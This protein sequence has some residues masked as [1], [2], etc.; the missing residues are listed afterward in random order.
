MRRLLIL[1]VASVF[2]VAG[3]FAT[4][5]PIPGD[6]AV[7]RTLQSLFGEAPP[8]AHWLTET[9]KPPLVVATMALAAGLAWLS[10]SWRGALGIPL[11]F[12]LAWLSDKALRAMIFAPRPSSD[13]IAVAGPSSASG[14][15]STFGLVY[16]SVFGAL[17]ISAARGGFSLVARSFALLLILVGTMARVVLGGHWASQMLASVLLGLLAASIACNIS[18]R[19]L[20]R[21]AE[22]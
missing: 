1:T 6:L 21:E 16:G 13:W 3:C 10:N 17:F 18:N 5:G 2:A 9:A 7:S 8:W 11:A 15:P 20:P 22:R 12:G 4:Q 14:L 19:L